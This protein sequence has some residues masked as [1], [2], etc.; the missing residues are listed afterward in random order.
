MDQ[1]T[2][3]INSKFFFLQWVYYFIKPTISIDG[4]EPQKMT[5]GDSTYSVEP[6]QHT[7]HIEIPYV[8]MKI[9]KATETVNV[10]AGET[11]AL[12]YRPP[13][14]LFMSGKL[15]PAAAAA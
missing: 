12:E 11:T 6:G 3:N 15:R 7:V 13:I 14:I 2:I 1:G 9:A 5:W 10:G 4:A 8:V